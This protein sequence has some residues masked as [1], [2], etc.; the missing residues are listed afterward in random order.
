AR[1]R[2][3]TR[4]RS[5]ARPRIRP[6]VRPR[7]RPGPSPNLGV[8][9]SQPFPAGAGRGLAVPGGAGG[10]RRAQ[11]DGIEEE[12][13]IAVAADALPAEQT[14]QRLPEVVARAFDRRLP[15]GKDQQAVRPRL[16]AEAARVPDV[17]E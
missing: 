5:R 10:G 1:T 8:Y 17:G 2:T 11:L 7:I 14:E 13:E 15:E 12:L 4:T 3:R 16:A 6:R 9:P